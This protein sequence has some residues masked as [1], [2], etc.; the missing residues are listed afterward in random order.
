MVPPPYTQQCIDQFFDAIKPYRDAYL[1]PELVFVAL[2]H[3]SKFVLFQGCLLFNFVPLDLQAS[4][5]R[6]NNVWA[7]RY[8]L[9]ELGITPEK[10]VLDILDG[11]ITTPE[12]NLDF[13]SDHP[14]SHLTHFT[15]FH[16]FGLQNQ[17]RLNVLGISGTNQMAF[18]RQP[19]IDWELKAAPTPFDNL[20][21]LMFDYK[22]GTIRGNTISVEA[23]AYNVALVRFDSKVEGETAFPDI[24]LA[25]GLST[26]KLTLGYRIFSQG[27]VISRG[28]ISGNAMTWAA[29]GPTQRGV[30]KLAIP[31]GSLVHCVVSY[32]GIAQHFGWLSDRSKILNSRR[33]VFEAFDEKL[34]L[35]E[36]IIEKA[37]GRSIE[38]R[39]FEAAMSWVL[40]MLGFSVAYL[41][42]T[43][44]TQEAAD[45]IAT[46][47]GGHIA[48][49]ECTTGIL[50]AENKLT[51]LHERTLKVRKAIESSDN[52]HVKVLP[53]VMTSKTREEIEPDLEMANRLGIA[54][55]AR[56]D[57]DW[58]LQRTA[59]P[60]N[61][62][63]F[64]DQ[65]EQ[66]VHRAQEQEA[67]GEQGTLPV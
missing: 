36:D 65:L 23:I 63:Q 11:R 5:F 52:R 21:E 4:R 64:Y 50:K 13:P 66:G 60:P 19:H 2:R 59:L 42:G 33:A 41:G 55:L 31:L 62:D 22:L 24:R 40:W 46:A 58:A 35:V 10:L 29:D 37:R 28:V 47:P 38:A 67:T 15:P 6:S 56:E 9:N 54:V 27:R 32:D 17:Q 3:D 20:Q 61:A 45:I 1:S 12:G 25:S 30:C 49:V 26:D 57:I 44:R 39:D 43:R 51:L 7:G 18:L 53:V 14:G 16:S 8:S 34:R 48:I